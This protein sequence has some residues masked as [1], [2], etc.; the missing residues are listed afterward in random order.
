MHFVIPG[1]RLRITLAILFTLSSYTCLIA[2]QNRIV[3]TPTDNLIP[4]SPEASALAKYAQIPVGFYTGTPQISIPVWTLQEG[5]INL[6]IS[7]SYHAS[8]IKVEE[9]ASRVGADWTLNAGGMITRTAVGECDEYSDSLN[10]PHIRHAAGFFWGFGRNYTP[11]SM[12][13]GNQCPIDGA[14]RGY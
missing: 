2:Q 7:L 1:W 8:G 6:N 3:N 4:P 9:I 14:L 12:F 10:R 5:D 11:E 13:T